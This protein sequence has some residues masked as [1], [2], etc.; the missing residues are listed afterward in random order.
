MVFVAQ[1]KFVA[2]NEYS[3]ME[4]SSLIDQLA[5]QTDLY[6]KMITEGWG[7]EDEFSQCREKITLIQEAIMTKKR[8]AIESGSRDENHRTEKEPTAVRGMSE[9]R[10]I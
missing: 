5:E 4:L 9:K 6:K 10:N 1:N 8:A 7:T 2:M 3:E